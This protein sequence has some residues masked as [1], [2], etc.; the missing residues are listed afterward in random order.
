MIKE[1]D[2]GRE[3]DWEKA[4]VDFGLGIKDQT[5]VKQFI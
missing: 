2:S 4:I 1:T 3:F 5:E